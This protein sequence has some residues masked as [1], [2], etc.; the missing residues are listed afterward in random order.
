MRT[1]R[2]R[3]T[4]AA[5]QRVG[6]VLCPAAARRRGCRRACVCVL[7]CSCRC[8]CSQLPP[9][10]PFGRKQSPVPRPLEALATAQAC[11]G[12]LLLGRDPPVAALLTACQSSVHWQ[13]RSAATVRRRSSVY[14]WRPGLGARLTLSMTGC[15]GDACSRW[16]SASLPAVLSTCRQS[17]IARARSQAEQSRYAVD[18]LVHLVT[19]CRALSTA[20]G[21]KC[22]I[23]CTFHGLRGHLRC[24]QMLGRC[25][26]IAVRAMQVAVSA[27]LAARTR[28]AVPRKLWHGA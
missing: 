17:R 14:S 15:I 7:F 25:F 20:A 12:T 6:N 10:P 18:E 9:P 3:L 24:Q 19:M 11:C 4:P 28:S 1:S 5:A 27:L 22:A 13:R 2:P 21:R 8:A 26:R 16:L 23:C